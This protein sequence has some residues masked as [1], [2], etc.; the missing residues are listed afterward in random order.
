MNT[1]QF[2]CHDD[3]SKDFVQKKTHIS[4][5]DFSIASIALGFGVSVD[6]YLAAFKCRK[7]SW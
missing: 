3:Y 2:G 4:D 6:Q 1:E 5:T 7:K